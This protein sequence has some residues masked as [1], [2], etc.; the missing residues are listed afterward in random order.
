MGYVLLALPFY[1]LLEARPGRPPRRPGLAILGFFLLLSVLL[2]GTSL[3]LPRYDPRVEIEKVRRLQQVARER[4]AARETERLHRFAQ[5]QGLSLV[6]AI[7]EAHGG[8]V[9]VESQEGRGS[10][11]SFSLPK[12]G[13]Q[14]GPVPPP[15]P[16]DALS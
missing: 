7:V 3:L 9:S 13:P 16:A 10:I 5:Q 1:L 6:K 14:A 11:F 4:E 8:Q 15:A 2:T 12:A